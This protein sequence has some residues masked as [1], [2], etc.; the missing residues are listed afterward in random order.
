MGAVVA[1]KLDDLSVY[2]RNIIRMAYYFSLRR[3]RTSLISDVVL[4]AFS[5]RRFNDDY[6]DARIASLRIILFLVFKVTV[7]YNI[8]VIQRCTGLDLGS[9]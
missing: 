7:L 4:R 6:Y 2:A 3:V 5:A 1:G 8:I 9:R